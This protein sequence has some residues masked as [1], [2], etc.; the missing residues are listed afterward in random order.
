MKKF[1]T[2]AALF[3]IFGMFA[4][5]YAQVAVQSGK[6]S[7]N[8]DTPG[9]TLDKNTGDRSVSID[10][11]FLVPFETKPDIVLSVVAIDADKAENMRY[12]VDAK[13]I[14]RDGFTIKINTWGASRIY[15]ITGNWIAHTK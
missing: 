9:Y 12:S 14:S 8:A 4:T 15:A 13:S 6:F 10:V 1:L 5:A 2:V 11:T 7:A 3:L